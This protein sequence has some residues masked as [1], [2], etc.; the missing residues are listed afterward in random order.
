MKKLLLGIALILFG[1]ALIIIRRAENILNGDFI[2][3]VCLAST[4]A[5][6]VCAVWGFME[7]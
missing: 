5:G 7:E 2:L 1:I 4:V 6:I 3:L